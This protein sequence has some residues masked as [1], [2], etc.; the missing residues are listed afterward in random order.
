[1]SKRLV[2]LCLGILIAAIL[3]WF[4]STIVGYFIIAMVFSAVL[5]T[6]TNYINQIQ[7]AGIQLPRAVAVM[8]SFSIFAGIIALFV[9]LFIPL[10]S[11]QIEFISV[12]DYNSLF[13]T[14]ISPIDYIEKF[15]IE[16][17]WVNEKEGFLMTELQNYFLE[18]FKDMKFGNVINQILDTT[19]TVLIGAISVMFI[20]FFLLYEKGLFRRNIIALIPNAYFEVSISAIYKIEKLLSNY[21]FGLLIQMFSIFTLVSIGLIVSEVK[22]ALTIAI[23]AAIAN[24]IPY[25]GP[26]LGASFGLIVS[27]STQ[28]QQTQDTAFSIL[29]IK[30]IIVFLIVQFS[31]N[32]LLQPIIFS[33]SIKAHPLEIFSVVFMGAALAGA[34]GMIFAIPVY[35]ILRVMALEFWKGYKEYRIFSKG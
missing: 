9:L 21:L 20:S 19:S 26:I 18:F 1:M 31:D 6:P 29:A 4:F 15:L 28:L 22:Y 7:I 35:T 24:L 5:Q 13:S 10:V 33:R 14:I 30:V 2:L 11:E 8:L 34:V 3:S 17:K 23:F 32:L 27:L 16:K 25:I 12:L